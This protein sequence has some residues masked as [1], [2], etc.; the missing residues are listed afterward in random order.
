M[1]ALNSKHSSD[2]IPEGDEC[3]WRKQL[4]YLNTQVVY[5]QYHEF[6]LIADQRV[7]LLHQFEPL[8]H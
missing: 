4:I 8:L 3:Y 1:L 6:W 7:L 2:L 5:L